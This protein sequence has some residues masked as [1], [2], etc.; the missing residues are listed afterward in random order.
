[1]RMSSPGPRVAAG[2]R[3][4]MER[5]MT[6]AQSGLIRSPS[7]AGRLILIFC[8]VAVSGCQLP[9]L[10]PYV[11]GTAELKAAV[12]AAGAAVEQDLRN[13]PDGAERADKLR[14]LWAARNQAM[15]ALLRYAQSLDA[16][17]AA[18]NSGAESAG[19]MADAVQELAGAAGVALPGGAAAAGV[20]IDTARFIYSQIALVRAAKHLEKALEEAQ[21]AVERIAELMRSDLKDLDELVQATHQLMAMKVVAENNAMAGYRATLFKALHQTRDLSNPMA[22]EEL[23]QLSRLVADVE[24]RHAVYLDKLEVIDARQRASRQLISATGSALD[25][26]AAAHADLVAAVRKRRTVNTL[27]LVAAAVEVRDLVNRI[28]QL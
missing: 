8:W 2:V 21:P 10:G 22:R 27:A 25:A 15:S 5:W 17:V 7:I 11:G 6:M 26:W 3:F 23:E 12:A 19:K 18:G 14:L 13:L 16:I 4:W 24:V 28:R 1:M 9:D 20:A